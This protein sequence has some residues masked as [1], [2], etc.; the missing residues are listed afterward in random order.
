MAC[1]Y[2]NS[3]FYS[4]MEMVRDK[5]TY[6]DPMHGNNGDTLILMG[7][8]HVLQKVGCKVVESPED[9]EQILINGGGLMV[10]V[11]QTDFKKYVHYRHK[12]LSVPLIMGP[13]TFRFRGVNFKEICEINSSP[14]ILFA[15]ENNSAESLRK[16]NLPAHCQVHTS[17]DL[18]FE[19]Y[20]SDF[21]AELLT[22]C[23]GKHILIAM[24][25]DVEGS[26][27]ILIKMKGTWL[28]KKIRRPLSWLRDRMVA[29]MSQD[30]IERIIKQ[31]EVPKRLPRIYRDVSSSVSFEYFVASIRDAA[32][33]ITDRL[34]VG[35]L[36]HLLNKR[37]VLICSG[38]YHKHK[39]KGVYELSMSGPESRTTLFVRE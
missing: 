14:F 16:A 19:L 15:R 35:V 27:G 37:A 34:H 1:Q 20:D 4:F 30:I 24:R 10:D 2:K 32:L 23:Q 29:R 12:Y 13:S 9:A 28:P 31:E 8:K 6:F 38:E 5:K 22:K 21:V 11:Y 18:A 25:K 39:M 33:I 7:A 26:A 17:H 3:N 36:G